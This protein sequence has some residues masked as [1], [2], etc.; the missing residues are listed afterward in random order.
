[1][2]PS[3][4][5]AGAS[6]PADQPAPRVN[7]RSARWRTCFAANRGES[8]R[9]P[10]HPFDMP[11]RIRRPSSHSIRCSGHGANLPR[12]QFLAAGDPRRTFSDVRRQPVPSHSQLSPVHRD[13]TARLPQAGQGEPRTRAAPARRQ[14]VSGGIY[15]WVQRPE[16]HDAGVQAYIRYHPGRL[17]HGDLR[18]TLA[19][20]NSVVDQLSGHRVRRSS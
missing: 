18:L 10:S 14:T 3:V 12:G 20:T 19:F 1:M 8:A 6:Q 17:R 4:R 9:C 2:C 11:S 13:A 7:P 5:C 16:S 15:M